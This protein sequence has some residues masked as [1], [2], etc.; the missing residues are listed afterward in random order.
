LNDFNA[1]LEHEIPKLRRYA[2]ALR[3]NKSEADDLVQDSLLRAIS[4]GHLWE[5]GTNL[6][7]WL[8]TIM[9]NQHVNVVRRAVREGVK[10]PIDDVASTLACSPMQEASLR[11]RD[12]DR[13][14]ARLPEPQRQ[15]L[16][17]TALEGRR[18]G[19]I[20]AALNVPSGTVRSRLSRARAAVR[21]WIDE[22][23]ECRTSA[24]AGMMAAVRPS[25]ALLGPRRRRAQQFSDAA[26]AARS[27]ARSA[28]PMSIRPIRGTLLRAFRG[29]PIFGNTWGAAKYS[30]R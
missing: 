21:V 26:D 11:L 7:A 15:V 13:A 29:N 2:L 16:L 20:A 27:P 28:A 24:G 22:N 12:L 6:G 14:M 18:Y 3:R 25:A 5:H 1:L 8:F 10:V 9:H 30:K 4:K 23:E 17:L 19:E